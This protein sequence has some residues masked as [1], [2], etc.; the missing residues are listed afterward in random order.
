MEDELYFY[1]KEAENTYL[2]EGN[3]EVFGY[4]RILLEENKLN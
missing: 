3:P 1:N 4:L 2:M